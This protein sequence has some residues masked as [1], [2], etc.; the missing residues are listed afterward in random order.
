MSS[1][2]AAKEIILTRPEDWHKWLKTVRAQVDQDT[3]NCLDPDLEDDEVIDLL[4]RPDMP[5]FD[6]VKPNAQNLM[7]LNAEQKRIYRDLRSYYSEELK[8]YTRQQDQLTAARRYIIAHISEQKEILLE[9]DLTVRQW[10]AMLKEDTEPSK[11]HMISEAMKDYY[12]A[13]KPLK[14]KTLGQWLDRW[15]LAMQQARK[16]K[17]G[18]VADGQWLRDLAE[19]MKPIDTYFYNRLRED[20]K[21]KDKGN[22]GRF[23][24]VARDLREAYGSHKSSSMSYTMRGGALAVRFNESDGEEG[25]NASTLGEEES[26]GSN[27]RR[28]RKRSGTESVELATP[29]KRTRTTCPACRVRGHD[30]PNC[31]AV[32]PELKPPEAL[33]PP[34][35][36]K[37]K[38]EKAL[39][40][41][42]LAAKVEEI[43]K[44]KASTAVVIDEA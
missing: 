5:G 19:V 35:S 8:Q 20:S 14:G 24:G 40:D 2:T 21:D 4:E 22:L 16:H 29:T 37:E 7:D 30:L 12:I 44:E 15:E 43:R 3:W 26:S 25:G 10:L 28:G 9:D 42:E 6:K 1:Q 39:K 34:E 17:I 41:P 23:M 36:R 11:M 13:L 27:S 38:A 33:T 18:A 32:F 31:W